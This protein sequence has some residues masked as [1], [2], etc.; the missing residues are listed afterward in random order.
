MK[1]TVLG[2]LHVPHDWQKSVQIDHKV[3][4]KLSGSDLIIATL[5]GPIADQNTPPYHKA[6]P[7]IRQNRQYLER[8]I[9]DLGIGAF[10]LANNHIFDYG[11][12]G[13]QRTLEY[14]DS[15]GVSRFGAGRS[16][17]EI[18]RPHLI[19]QNAKIAIFGAGESQFGCCKFD[20]QI[21]GYAWI[22]SIKLHQ[23]ITHYKNEGYFIVLLTHAGLE[24][25]DSPLPE[26]RDKYKKL[27]E[28]GADLIIGSHPHVIQGKELYKGK[29]IYYSLGNFFFPHD[30]FESDQTT[31]SLG[32]EI[33]F[34]DQIQIS[35]IFFQRKSNKLIS[36]SGHEPFYEL[37]ALLSDKALEEQY[38]KGINEESI[39]HWNDYYKKYYARLNTNESFEKLPSLLQKIVRRVTNKYYIDHKDILLQ[40]NI[41]IE[42]HRYV[43]ERALRLLNST[44]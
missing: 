39:K 41:A 31:I 15:L 6:G 34:T 28:T 40:H 20:D 14:L 26:W 35:E 32:L 33:D 16:Q 25:F 36:K 4:E 8:M 43:V 19:E 30:E 11:E 29:W 5:E 27:V 7:R 17:N 21:V 44:Y 3:V 1:I 18:Y 24:M 9:S 37:N 22:D 13:L 12:R 10:T 2:D 42:T 38:Y 23:Q